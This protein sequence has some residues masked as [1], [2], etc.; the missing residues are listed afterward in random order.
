MINDLHG[1]FQANDRVQL[2]KTVPTAIY[3]KYPLHGEGAVK[4]R[5]DHSYGGVSYFSLRSRDRKVIWNF[6][7]CQKGHSALWA[8]WPLKQ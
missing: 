2:L 8:P 7:R 5:N 4:F 6:G 1:C 3:L